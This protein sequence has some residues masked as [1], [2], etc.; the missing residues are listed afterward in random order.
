MSSA[1]SLQPV[2][3]CIFDMDGLLLD[4]E[5][6]YE[7]SMREIC[8]SFGKE[9]PFAVRIKVM[10]QTEQKSAEIVIKEQFTNV[11]SRISRRAG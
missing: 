2:T 4:T 7:D 6:I 11:N 9:F 5:Q 10:G 1:N 8:A 3:H